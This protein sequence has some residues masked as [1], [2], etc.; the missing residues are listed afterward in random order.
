MLLLP[1]HGIHDISTFSTSSCFNRLKLPDALPPSF[2]GTAVTYSYQLEAHARFAIAAVMPR[3]QRH[4][5]G[6]SVGSDGMQVCCCSQGMIS[7]Q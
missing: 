7:T 6:S 5:S 1:E 4:P 3:H 2:K